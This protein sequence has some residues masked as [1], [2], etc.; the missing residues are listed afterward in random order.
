[1]IGPLGQFIG[2][3]VCTLRRI[4]VVGTRAEIIRLLPLIPLLGGFCDDAIPH[5]DPPGRI[6]AG[7]RSR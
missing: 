7:S 1:M 4:T 2:E 3:E 6:L 5:S